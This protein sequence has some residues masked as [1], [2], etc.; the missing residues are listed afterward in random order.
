MGERRNGGRARP[1]DDGCE[2][3]TDEEGT[4]DAVQ[5]QEDGENTTEREAASIGFT[6]AFRTGWVRT[7]Q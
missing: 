1:R 5:H 2:E 3:D 7:R 4:L 6:N